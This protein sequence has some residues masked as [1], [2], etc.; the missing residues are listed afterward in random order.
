MSTPFPSLALRVHLS[1][2]ERGRGGSF[3]LWE[4]VRMRVL[5]ADAQANFNLTPVLESY[6]VTHGLAAQRFR[7]ADQLI[8]G[9]FNALRDLF[10]L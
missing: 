2:G 4:K 10:V 1:H 5:V 8:G 6:F 7:E 3:S 9:F